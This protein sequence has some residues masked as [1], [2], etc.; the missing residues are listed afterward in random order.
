[1]LT[2]HEAHHHVGNVYQMYL[3]RQFGERGFISILISLNVR[4]GLLQ[5]IYTMLGIIFCS[6]PWM[7]YRFCSEVERTGLHGEFIK[8]IEKE[9]RLVKDF[10]GRMPTKVQ[11][12]V[13]QDQAVAV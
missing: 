10:I 9:G 2:K 13:P 11:I 4:I 12:I 1:M 8:K 5:T 3:P 6:L 7:Y